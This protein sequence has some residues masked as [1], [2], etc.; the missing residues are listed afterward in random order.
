MAHI[1]RLSDYV[2]GGVAQ[3]TILEGLFVTATVSG[4]REELPNVR[5]A[6]SGTT[7]PVYVAI[8]PP[9]NFARPTDSRMYTAGKLLVFRQDVNT[10]WADPVVNATYYPQG[11]S[12]Y[13]APTAVSG[14]LLQLHRDTTVTLTSGCFIDAAGIRVNDAL[15]KVADD[16]T[17]RAQLTTNAAVAVGWVE[18]YDADR[19]YL[20]ITVGRK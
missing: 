12:T 14:M 11:L 17:G 7:W 6:A 10:G 18:E 15:V 8:V 4:I 3:D 1:S 9:D 20:T 16:G 13:E 19:K 2:K 5:L